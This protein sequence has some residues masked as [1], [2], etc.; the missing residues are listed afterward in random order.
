MWQVWQA[1]AEAVR[2]RFLK[3]FNPFPIKNMKIERW[4]SIERFISAAK[5]LFDELLTRVK[6]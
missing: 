5:S 6:S 1:G 2:G 3:F 4:S